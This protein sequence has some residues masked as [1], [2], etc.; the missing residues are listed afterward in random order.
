MI[1]FIRRHFLKAVAALSAGAVGAVIWETVLK[2]ASIWLSG[3][4]MTLGTLGIATLRDGVYV[5][6]ARGLHEDPSIT[7][8]AMALGV[9]GVTLFFLVRSVV[10]KPGEHAVF[11]PA[12]SDRQD[13]RVERVWQ[14]AT[15]Q[16]NLSGRLEQAI[17]AN[18]VLLIV[19]T[20][21]LSRLFY[22]NR[23]IVH[24]R[25]CLDAATPF[26]S[27]QEEEEVLGQFSTMQTKAEFVAVTSRVEHVAHSNSKRTPEFTLW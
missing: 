22:I 1:E 11:E 12:N 18:V 16:T 15:S 14:R 19:C 23:A 7:L 2:P 26:L 25:Q 6:V 10:T 3:L 4:L 17:L 5:E 27:E 24:F 21:L 8:V 20:I 13:Q 9:L